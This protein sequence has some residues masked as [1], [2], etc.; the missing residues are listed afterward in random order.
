VRESYGRNEEAPWRDEFNLP[1]LPLAGC[2]CCRWPLGD[3][4]GS[5]SRWRAYRLLENIFRGQVRLIAL[6]R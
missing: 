1:S 5:L 4:L 6:A 3:G 2:W